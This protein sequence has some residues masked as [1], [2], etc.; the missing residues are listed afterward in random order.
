MTRSLQRCRIPA[1]LDPYKNNQV[2]KN[3]TLANGLVRGSINEVF[4]YTNDKI[5]RGFRK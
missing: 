2:I 5:L 4:L 3:T 1:D